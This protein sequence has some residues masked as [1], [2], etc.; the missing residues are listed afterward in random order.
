L[1][2]HTA[3]LPPLSNAV[4]SSRS[5]W[6][7]AGSSQGVV[8]GGFLVIRTSIGLIKPAKFSDE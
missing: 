5:A 7:F 6:L 2:L 4:S 3:C 1:S 8:F